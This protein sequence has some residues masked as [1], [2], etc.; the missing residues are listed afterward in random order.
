MNDELPGGEA[1][2]ALPDRVE[3][4]PDAAGVSDFFLVFT[5]N[6]G[7]RAANLEGEIR[8]R[9]GEPFE[10]RASLRLRPIDPLTIEAWVHESTSEQQELSIGANFF[11][12]LEIE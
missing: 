10:A 8:A 5:K 7:E 12:V 2:V 4:V 11:W 3:L 9:V 6:F 1:A